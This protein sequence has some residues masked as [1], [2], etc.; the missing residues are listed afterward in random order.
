MAEWLKSIQHSYSSKAGIVSLGAGVTLLAAHLSAPEPVKLLL[1]LA[2]LIAGVVSL[3][4]ARWRSGQWEAALQ[5]VLSVI[6]GFGLLFCTVHA[7]WWMALAALAVLLVA[8]AAQTSTERALLLAAGHLAAVLVSFAVRWWVVYPELTG[9]FLVLVLGLLVGGQI[10][11]ITLL[12]PNASAAPMTPEM[13]FNS[14]SDMSHLVMQIRVTSDG[15]ARATDAINQVVL[16]LATGA[17]EQ[18]TAIGLTHERLDTFL[19]LSEEIREQARSVTLMAG[20]TAE[21][22]TKGQTSIEQAIAGIE[23]VRVQ[24]THIAETIVRLGELTQRIDEIILSV[25]EIATQSN[26]LALNASIE[27]ARAGVHGRGFAVVADEVRTLSQQS[28]SAAQQVRAILG[29]IQNAMK[30]S[31]EATQAGMQGVDNGVA[32]T[33]EANTIMQSLSQSVNESFKSVKA[34]YDVI[35][36]QM[37]DLEAIAI[38][39]ERIERITQQNL[40]STR[41]VETVSAGLSH[42]SSELQMVVA[43]ESGSVDQDA[44]D[45]GKE[46]PR[47]AQQQA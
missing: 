38:T 22:S 10:A 13:A 47:Q 30:Q 15:L 1:A 46:N 27:A 5:I 8:L 37:E 31:V 34:I 44:E 12:R 21:F 3:G 9:E 36:Q 35:R 29:E 33:R 43:Q 4:L 28:T 25:S 45:Y 14:T 41:M 40:A 17:S 18:V 11:A 23:A 6:T 16:Q 2:Y 20:H 24:V 32:M 7:A 19:K 39:I 26:L 42:L